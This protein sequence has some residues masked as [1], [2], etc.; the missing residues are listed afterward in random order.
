[1][2]SETNEGRLGA[3]DMAELGSD[4]STVDGKIKTEPTDECTVNLCAHGSR[5]AYHHQARRLD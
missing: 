4:V 5:Y 1:M 2:V 3:E